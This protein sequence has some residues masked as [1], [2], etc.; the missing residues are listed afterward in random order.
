[1]AER[2]IRGAYAYV[3]SA[4]VPWYV[5]SVPGDGGMDWGWSP[6]AKD[7][8]PLSESEWERFVADQHAWGRQAFCEND[9]I[10]EANEADRAYFIRMVAGMIK[11]GEEMNGERYEQDAQ[12]AIETLGRL[13]DEARKLVP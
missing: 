1:M 2:I 13:I 3:A 5:A 9:G 11:D 6:K 7:A 12:D 10:A 4:L 8:I